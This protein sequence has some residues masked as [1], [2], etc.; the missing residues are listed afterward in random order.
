MEGGVEI[1]KGT[2]AA[3]GLVTL[4]TLMYEILL[5]RIFSVTMWYHFAF[6]AISVAMFGM[7]VVASH[8]CLSPLRFTE[9]QTHHH[10][11][12]SSLLF[13]LSIVISFL[14]HLSIPFAVHP[15]LTGLYIITLTYAV[16]AVPF[17]FS[18]ICV[19]LALTRFP[20][21]VS[22]LYAADLAG[23]ALG[24]VLL[25]GTLRITDGPT[26]VI[27][28]ALFAGIG[29]VCFSL[30]ASSPRLTRLALITCLILGSF[31]AA[32]TFL[33]HRQLSLLRLVWVR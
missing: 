4:A 32:H 30:G 27:V 25:V 2:Y 11:A 24:C 7:T 33:V 17:V 29:A 12:L 20:A 18:G 10:L 22:R 1:R 5:T 31:A 6:V 13:A 3:V 14:T 8:V 23:G 16:I 28:V 9:Q 21:Q 26:A 19:C 15:S